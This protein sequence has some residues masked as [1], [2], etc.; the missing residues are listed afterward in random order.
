LLIDTCKII[1]DSGNYSLCWIG[2]INENTGRME[3]M[4][5]CEI[6]L[7]Y[8]ETIYF[9]LNQSMYESQLPS[10]NIFN[11]GKYYVNNDI[12]NDPVFNGWRDK[13]IP[14]KLNSIAIFP[15]IQNLKTIGAVYL[16]SDKKG[17]FK[18]D[19]LMLLQILSMNLSLALDKIK[20]DQD[21]KTSKPN[22]LS[23][24][25]ELKRQNEKLLITREK[26]E[27]LNRLKAAFLTNMSHK[28]R[29]P[30][31]SIIGFADLLAKSENTPEERQEYSQ[32]IV[33]QS[34]YLL[35]LI[36]NILQISKL[37]TDTVP[38]YKETVSLNKLLDELNITCLNKLE[39]SKKNIGLIY[40]KHPDETE[41]KITTDVS[42]FRQIFVNLL[43][44]SIKFTDSGEINFGYHSHDKNLL[45]CFVSDTGVGINPK[46]R[47]DLFDI[48]KQADKKSK[49]N[50]GDTGLG[51]AICKGNAQ[52]LGGNIWVGSEPDK[53]T[54]FYFTV[55]YTIPEPGSTTIANPA[56][57]S[58]HWNTHEILLVEDD[59]CT[60]QYLTK[61]LEQAGLKLNVAHNGKETEELYKKLSEID[62]ILLD[63]SL[64]DINGLDL[65]KQ[66]KSIRRDI[67]IIVQT[68]VTV[69]DEGKQF[70]DAGCDGYIT[71]PYKRD[72]I[73][74]A[75]NSF[76]TA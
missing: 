74:S 17:F 56:H 64:P 21:D 51:L 37:D 59:A 49:R 14:P 41:F 39:S 71:K 32:L 4:P 35:Q 75:I 25:K 62:L 10:E 28:I 11:V 24:E 72:E 19:E 6:D 57:K 36:N 15:L 7:E 22:L 48:F 34:N 42:K 44:N 53:G 46:D 23:K 16:Y 76:I 55:K 27:E 50:Y 29:T 1:S 20:S 43:D 2:I 73:L 3:P 45:T 26:T 60:I 33:S 40:R 12:W 9:A 18:H 54:T 68:A 5:E 69:E 70:F 13:A 66:I 38:L 63:M 8:L 47:K 61:I 65:V 58:K 67:P 52:L 31:N 30:L